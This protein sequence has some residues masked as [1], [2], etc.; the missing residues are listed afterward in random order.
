MFTWAFKLLFRFV[1]LYFQ[2]GNVSHG[3]YHFRMLTLQRHQKISYPSET[4]GQLRRSQ[5]YVLD[6]DYFGKILTNIWIKIKHRFLNVKIKLIFVLKKTQK[7]KESNSWRN[8]KTWTKKDNEQQ[9]R[10]AN[11]NF[12]NCNKYFNFKTAFTFRSLNNQY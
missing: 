3:T 10:A 1:G 9:K 2:Y 12:A 4:K 6:F 7:N 11:R 8:A 5:N